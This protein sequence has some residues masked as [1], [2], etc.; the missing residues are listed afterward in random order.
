MITA[1]KV[2]IITVNYRHAKATLDFMNSAIRLEA[3]EE[4][5]LLIVDNSSGDDSVDSIR[6][7]ASQ[8]GNVEVL[9]SEINRG[10]FGGVKWA[11]D[12]YL[13][14]HTAPDWVLVCNN[15]IVFDDSR[16]LLRLL[17][18]DPAAAGVISPAVI[19]RLTGHD[20]NPSIM[21]RPNWLRMLRYRL[22]LSNYYAAWVTQWLSPFVRRARHKFLKWVTNARP[23]SR[24]AIYAPHGSLL[25]F[26]RKF[27]E[28]GGRIDDGCFLYA[29][30]FCVAEMCLHLALPVIHEPQ[31]RVWHNEH[32]TTGRML[33]RHTYAHQKDGLRYALARYKSSYRELGTTGPS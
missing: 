17:E 12:Q 33:T 15:D 5:N 24:N 2:L 19:S 20:A 29:E 4:T 1:S 30:E 9:E 6:Q 10:Y 11:L 3:S 22:W 28:M 16:F 26:S 18:E 13:A 23:A 8:F 31:L 27:F 25:I 21:R 14:R 7:A 32:Q